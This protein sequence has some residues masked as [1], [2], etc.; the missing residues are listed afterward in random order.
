M[1]ARSGLIDEPGSLAR[2]CRA[3][4]DGPVLF[5]PAWEGPELETVLGPAPAGFVRLVDLVVA[6]LEELPRLEIGEP[7][8]ERLRADLWQIDVELWRGGA[9]AGAQPM[10]HEPAPITGLGVSCDGG[11]VHVVALRRNADGAF[12]PL[13]TG[14]SDVALGEL[15]AADTLVLRLVVAAPEKGEIAIT[16]DSSMTSPRELRVTLP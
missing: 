16:L 12:V 2:F 8:V 13:P 15:R 6:M 4:L 3:A 1:C 14:G 9:L 10:I 11:M 5:A 7:K